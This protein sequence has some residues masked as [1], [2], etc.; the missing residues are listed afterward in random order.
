MTA[1]QPPHMKIQDHPR[2]LRGFRPP[3]TETS[4][5]GIQSVGSGTGRSIRT[6]ARSNLNGGWVNAKGVVPWR[7]E[8]W[9]LA[10]SYEP[11]EAC[12]YVW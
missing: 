3:G 10:S 5:F 12:P 6:A 8:A 2:R 7:T 9:R 1:V 4:G 11:V